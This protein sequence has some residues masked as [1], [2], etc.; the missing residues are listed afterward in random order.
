MKSNFRKPGKNKYFII[1]EPSSG[2]VWS[3]T[4]KRNGYCLAGNEIGLV[5]DGEE[6]LSD[7]LNTE[8]GLYSGIGRV[9]IDTNVAL[10]ELLDIM[11]S[12]AFET[13][14]HNC[15]YLYIND[16]EIGKESFKDF[17]NWYTLVCE[18][19]RKTSDESSG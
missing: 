6:T 3:A 17:L 18:G 12:S 8:G 16:K 13:L 1:E 4:R 14:L 11:S 10:E 19:N 2:S 9:E 15:D 5:T 7:A